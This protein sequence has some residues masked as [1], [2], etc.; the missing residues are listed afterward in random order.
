MSISRENLIA[1][2]SLSGKTLSD[3][4]ALNPSLHGELLGE[5]AEERRVATDVAFADASSGLRALVRAVDLAAGANRDRPVKAVLADLLDDGQV[6]TALRAELAG[7]LSSLAQVDAFAGGVSS[8]VALKEH[9]LFRR[10]VEK[11]GVMVLANAAQLSAGKTDALLNQV[12]NV[13]QLD[14]GRLQRLVQ[15][16]ALTETEARRLG[17]IASVAN[18]AGG[19][20]GLAQAA[21]S[22]GNVTRPE[23][24]LRLDVAAWEGAITSSGAEPPDG[25]DARAYAEEL[26]RRVAELYPTETVMSRIMPRDVMLYSQALSGVQP[27]F[28]RNTKI[29]TVD[30]DALDTT[31]FTQQQRETLR[32]A[33]ANMRALVRLHPGLGLAEIVDRE[34]MSVPQKFEAI[35]LRLETLDRLQQ[36][37]WDVELL[38]LDLTPDSD[39]LKALNFTGINEQDRPFVVAELKAY[40]R[41][42]T[43]AG[44]IGKIDALLRTGYSSATAVARVDLDTFAQKTGLD[45]D[46]AS[47]IHRRARE[48][49]GTAVAQMGAVIDILKGGFDSLAVGNLGPSS[50]DYLRKLDG[51]TELFGSQDYCDCAHCQSILSPAAYFVDLMEFIEEHVTKHFFTG[52]RA[53]HVL[54]LKSRRPDL[55][56][57]PLTCENTHTQVPTLDIINEIL[58]NYIAQ[59]QG[60][61][62]ALSDRVAV[63][64][65]VYRDTLPSAVDSF[66]QPFLLPFARIEQYLGHF[67]VSRADVA[68]AMGSPAGVRAAA[69]LGLSMPQRDT[70][71][72]ARPQISFLEHVY[73]ADF[74]LLPD[75]KIDPI[76]T[77]VL[78][79]HTGIRRDELEILSAC[80]FVTARGAERPR[81]VQAKRSEDSVQ[82]DVERVHDLTPGALDRMHRFVRLARHLPWTLAE[83]DLAL[84]GIMAAGLAA[85]LDEAA[86]EALAAIKQIAARLHLKMEQAVTLFSLIPNVAPGEGK[87]GL[88]D[89]LF[90]AKPFTLADGPLPKPAVAFIHSAFRDAAPPPGNDAT[91]PRLMAGLQVDAEQLA[92]LI[93]E[94]AAPLGADLGPDAPEAARG[95]FLTQENLALLYRHARLLQALKVSVAQL[96]QLIAF[97]GIGG[98]VQTLAHVRALIEAHDLWKSSGLSLD[99][100]GFVTRG[101]VED[102]SRYPNAEGVAAT[103]AGEAMRERLT[104]FADTVFAFLPSVTEDQSRAIVAANAAAF[105]L[106]PETGLLRL[107][108]DFSS[109]GPLTIPPG[110]GLTA[111]AARSALDPLHAR[112]IL[113][114]KLAAHLG[115]PVDRLP[116]MC[117]MIGADLSAPG[118]VQA[119]HGGPT[120]ALE[121]IVADLAPLAMLFKHAAFDAGVLSYMHAFPDKFA[122]AD[123][124]ALTPASVKALLAYRTLVD[125]SA[126]SPFSAEPV[127][128][129]ADAMRGAITI[130][131]P[132]TKFAADPWIAADAL[133]IQRP[134]LITL[135]QHVT[136]PSTALEALTALAKAAALAQTLGL[137]G[138][139][140]GLILADGYDD[141]SRAADG[142]VATFRTN[143]PDEAEFEEKIAPSE[144]KIRSLQRDALVDYLIRSIHPE[145]EAKDELYQHFLVDV[146]LE[147]CARTSRV[148]A[149]ISS[150][151][152]YVHRILINLEQD[153][154]AP[155]DP[156][157]VHVPPAAIPADEWA[158]RKN[159]RV[160]EAN[161][162]VFLYPENYIEPDLRDDKSP[163]FQELEQTLLQQDINEQ[164]VLDAYTRYL[165]GFE[166]I[167]RLKIAG[168]YHDKNPEDRTDILHMFGV[169][170]SD[171]PVYYY[172]TAENVHYGET[173]SDRA[174]SWSPWRKIDVQIPV[175]TVS[176]VVYQ[177]RLIVFWIEISTQAKH[178]VSGGGSRFTGYQHTF[179]LRYTSL[180]LDG[181]WSPPQAV[182]LAGA[183]APYRSSWVSAPNGVAADP[184]A[185]YGES[186]HFRKVPRYDL[187][188]HDDEPL[189]GYT[190][191]GYAW[192]RCYPEIK[193]N[194][195]LVVTCIGFG[196]RAKIDF[197]ENVIVP[198]NPWNMRPPHVGSVLSIKNTRSL[199]NPDRTRPHLFFGLPASFLI[200][201]YAQTTVSRNA[202]NGSYLQG[203]I[204]A[205]WMLDH[206]FDSVHDV[207]LGELKFGD[208]LTIVNGSVSDAILTSGQDLI[209]LQCRPKSPSSQ[210]RSPIFYLAKRL[211]TRLADHLSR[212]LFTR[213]VD[214]L[215]DV[216][217]QKALGEPGL[218]F[219]VVDYLIDRTTKGE[220]DFTGSLGVYFR[221]MFFHIPALIASHL[222]VQGRYA[223]AQR[224]YHFIFDP[225]ATETIAV[226]PELSAAERAFR[227]RDRVWRYIE[228]RGL[229]AP[230]LRKTLTD[231][232]AL[233]A[234]KRDPF[235]PHAIARL[236]LSAY[237]KAIVMK[238]IDNLLDWGDSLF[239]QFTTESI[240]EAV[241]LYVMASDILG[242][243]PDKLG[244]CGEGNIAPK[245]YEAIAP[246][247]GAGE[248]VLIELE[249]WH[250]GRPEVAL[251]PQGL[252]KMQRATFVLET[253]RLAARGGRLGANAPPAKVMVPER[254]AVEWSLIDV[255]EQVDSRPGSALLA[256]E[257]DLAQA[258]LIELD[259]AEVSATVRTPGM[260]P[261]DDRITRGLIAR[262]LDRA[263]TGIGLWTASGGKD[264]PAADF[265]SVDRSWFDRFWRFGIAVIRQVSPVFCIPENK[266]LSAYWARVEDRLFKIRNCMDIAGVKRLPALF[267]PEIDPR[268]LVRARAAGLS[269]E[270]VLNATTGSLP[271]YRFAYLIEKA[272][273]ATAT[274]QAFGAALYAALERRDNEELSRLR[275]VHQQ[276]LLEM[277]TKLRELDLQVA[278]EAI[279]QLRR[280]KA[281]IEYRHDYY[282]GLLDGDLSAWE[283]TQQ[284]A[285]HAATIASGI[286]AL[287]QMLAGVLYLVP[288]LGSPFAMKYGGVEL[289][290]SANAFASLTRA[291]ATLSE[292]VSASAGL[293]AGFERRREGWEHQ[294]ELAEHEL[295]Q[296]EK[297]I[298]GA[299]L[300]KEI[301]ARSIDLHAESIK[302]VEEIFEFHNERF[303]N[304]GLFNHLATTLQRLYRDAY[305]GA[306][307][308]A[309]LA[310]QAYRFERNDEATPLLSPSYWEVSRAGLLAG[311]RLMIDLLAMERRFIETNLR[312]LEIDQ[313][314]SLAQLDPAALM[315][316]KE[317]GTTDFSIPELAFDLFY[318]G[319]YR[320][321]IRS[322][323]LTIPCVTGPFTNV[324]AT[325]TLTGSK[326]RRQPALGEAELFDVPLRRSTTVATSTAQ[327]DAG[328]LE[329]GFRDERYM[330]FEGSGAISSWRLTLPANFRPFDYQTIT[331]AIVHIA[332]TAEFDGAFRDEVEAVNGAAEG[333]IASVLS[334]TPLARTF[335][336][337]QDFSSVF[338]RLLH[339]PVD[340][341]VRIEITPRHFPLFLQGRSLQITGASLILRTPRD[342]TA[343]GLRIAVNGAEQTDFTREERFGGMFAR[344]LGAALAGSPV[345]TH[346]L[347]VRASGD[348]APDAPAPGD[349][350]ALDST[351]VHDI[352]L[353]IEFKPA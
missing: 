88:F 71:L 74:T 251:S 70:I 131:D 139:T 54:A 234:Y 177:G 342:Q 9:P 162:K 187:Y 232:A 267:A 141:L 123:F 102:E 341:E 120:D 19:H 118:V 77:K 307:A 132:V 322:V 318:P 198:M 148:V 145:F 106:V 49:A 133:R 229:D 241:M 186:A 125:V 111:A 28:Q 182:R 295:Q 189:A 170:Q 296:V 195:E 350:S 269:L 204:I 345:A 340:T 165:A 50:L 130:F 16:Q 4:A 129:N 134:L 328:V 79:R 257:R 24:L 94:L 317:T 190:L 203:R 137:D 40:Q 293:E 34:G 31:G 334:N 209:Y 78:L 112:G 92:A 262:P 288:Q 213:G 221:E 272:K 113:F 237:Q 329:F 174:A 263:R 242:P 168:V 152:L 240:H 68:A 265:G 95:F 21:I 12:H 56:T 14:D 154:R 235:N 268:L 184:L 353:Y 314:F 67:S 227:Q 69:A 276:N 333:T 312:A 8:D 300:R 222:N 332:Y 97:A 178:N 252:P 100:L 75:G 52:A 117:A 27:L 140:L 126:L 298:T 320:R 180:K 225:T 247:L 41:V 175:R 153:R 192:D 201:P 349:V 38:A 274:V 13:T 275:V 214:G 336:L 316:L 248:D 127:A 343:T 66:R 228:F 105:T 109:H 220:I 280:Q 7:K 215:L 327:N 254:R 171:P 155:E 83:V 10:S 294:V 53:S 286:G 15:E 169:T 167:A 278:D 284:G 181:T 211:G 32:A 122:I 98:P 64:S 96:F 266:D 65:A 301:A 315:R 76:E 51:F 62:G 344:A 146:Q 223:A 219:T 325:L 6:D 348:L 39:D 244:S 104:Q 277:T 199:D 29:T 191:R 163:L 210:A 147:G 30:F 143:Y 63:R 226:P 239:T 238:Y 285:R 256:T 2:G 321:R 11:A 323:R 110:I 36:H 188:A 156:A 5:V 233:E 351:K 20:L 236:R 282:Q 197:A 128:S 289:G 261:Q 144:D 157:H 183:S 216:E 273:Q 108:D 196:T 17:A 291:A 260:A 264:V 331:D 271:P 246:H 161:R 151:Q 158:W 337:R 116:V 33:H 245:T 231:G 212:A 160:W 172:C 306:L 176:P 43:L 283:R 179:S 55:W 230:K 45:R 305:G 194:G 99:D 90:N 46:S 319:Q 138:E 339:S 81:F 208:D 243:R 23:H 193:E 57:L 352:L 89:R 200:D 84:D 48:V 290:N 166:E 173:E 60:F 303:T 25:L 26:H 124:K 217:T 311:E 202:A 270:D 142:L 150:L 310:E 330:P 292:Q 304:L 326:V 324:G 93:R 59:R 299:K 73:G 107:S 335:S 85:A 35:C 119:L 22:V 121:A 3:V 206:F 346:R 18:L 259:A 82:N 302:Q 255:D 159:Y 135:L 258:G 164:T 224:W 72:I 308:M 103:I 58:E 42:Y 86:L 347:S 253:A 115:L 205:E 281:A 1:L 44:D 149:G 47:S 250:V 80:R 61:A 309:R 207:D 185:D 136:L 297:Q 287:Q 101:R 338:A 313:P 37:N 87:P 218:P 114:V 279:E 91:L 249:Q